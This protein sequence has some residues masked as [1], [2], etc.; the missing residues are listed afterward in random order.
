MKAIIKIFNKVYS[1]FPVYL[2]FDYLRYNKLIL[3]SWLLP[4][5]FIL[6]ITGEKFGIP[7]LYLVPEYMGSVNAVAFLF[8]GLATGSFIMAFHI[9]SYINMAHRHPFVIRFSRPFLTYSLNNSV[10]PLIYIV[11]FLIQSAYFQ[12][13]Y[14]LL[15]TGKIIVNL[16]MF[17]LGIIFFILFSFGFFYF[18]VRIMPRSFKMLKSRF[19]YEYFSSI[20]F[21]DKLLKRNADRKIKESPIY[22]Q[23]ETKVKFYLFSPFKI[24]RVGLFSHYSAEQFKRV[25][26]YQHINAFIYV[27]VILAFIILRGLLKDVPELILPAGASFMVFFTVLLLI[28]SLFYIIFEA[29]TVT[30]VFI[31]TLLLAYYSPFN[32]L[33]YNE[34]AYGLNYSIDKKIDVFSH[35]DYTEDSLNTIKILNKWKIKNTPKGSKNY[36]PKMVIVSTSGGGIKM[37]VWT[38]YVLG[39]IDSLLN[40]Q[41][42]PHIELITGASGGMVGAAYLRENYLRYLNGKEKAT[43]SMEK[44]NRMAK[45]ILNPIFYTFSMSDWFFR[46]QTF[47]Y[48][49][50]KYFKDRAYIFEQT[51]NDNLCGVMDKPLAAYKKPVSEGL[52]PIM[53]IAPSIENVGSRLY[54]SSI[55]ISYMTR[56]TKDMKIRNIELR[57]NYADFDADSLRFLTALRMN[58]TFPYV[59]PDVQMPGKPMLYILD[60]GLNDNYG[61]VSSYLFITEFKDWIKE[62]T[63]G[64]ILIRLDENSKVKYEYLSKPVENILRPLGSVFADYLNVQKQN[65]VSFVNSLY[66]L[67]PG[68][69]SMVHLGFASNDVHVPL[70]WH[71]TKRDKRALYNAIKNPHIQESIKYLKKELSGN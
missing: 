53:M 3:L 28:V 58:A 57:H 71:L 13:I 37:S 10:I 23:K 41:L 64:V 51:L 8:S 62:N 35:G 30:V 69:F 11:I 60:A 26:Q 29:W 52:I 42:M 61:L 21:I 31:V 18:L 63:S 66:K 36:K 20:P 25:F 47:T 5:L 2:L 67:L 33:K 46:L 68:K 19:N 14:E 7:T 40:G 54:I 16:L 6:N 45:D 15:P 32:M 48:K 50:K 9:A 22:Y 49:G 43:Y 12:K 44:C 55:G 24:R 34:S 70:S 39:Y 27:V 59:S 4:F 1:F 65:Y 38:Y 56:T 17:I